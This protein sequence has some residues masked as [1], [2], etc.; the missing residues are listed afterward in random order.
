M[1]KFVSLVI[2]DAKP[3]VPV[4]VYKINELILILIRK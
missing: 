4:V 2:C 1:I 3:K